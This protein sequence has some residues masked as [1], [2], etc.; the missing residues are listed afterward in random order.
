MSRLDFAPEIDDIKITDIKKGIGNFVPK[1]EKA[2]SFAALKTALRKAGYA[3]DSAEITVAGTLLRDDKGW[4]IEAEPSR[5]RFALEGKEISQ[6]LGATTGTRLE[7]TGDWQTVDSGAASREVIILHGAKKIA[8]D[9]RSQ[10]MDSSLEGIQVSLAGT[11]RTPGL[12][13]SPIRTTSPGLT[14]YKGGAIAPEYSF[15][16]QHLGSLKVDRHTF[17]INVSYTPT[18]DIQL[19]ADLPYSETQFESGPD[20]GSGRGLGNITLWGKYRFYR[21]LETWGD[22][23]AAVRIGVELPTGKKD[24]PGETALPVESFIRQ[25]LTPING[26]LS[27]HTDVAYSQ[28]KG[29]FIYGANIEGIL[30]SE[31]DGYR[32]GHEIQINTD[33]EYLLLP[34]KYQSPTKELFTILETSFIHKGHGHVDG[35]KVPGSTS[36]EFYLEPGLQYVA[37]SRLVFEASYQIPVVRNVGSVVLRTD[38]NILV[39][40]KYLY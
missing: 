3:L 25:Q 28:A 2:A 26:G 39:R 31:R 16:R 5:Q 9:K 37:T 32:L 12:F 22:R 4:W 11:I 7:I 18:S 30:R 34:F 17:Q 35:L 24:A 38:Q 10:A 20:S 36:T 13:F 21:I 19:E 6:K 1:P 40:M 33:F 29:R 23:Q 27:L 15:T 14:V 8:A